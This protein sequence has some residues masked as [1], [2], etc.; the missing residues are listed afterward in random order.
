MNWNETDRDREREMFHVPSEGGEKERS[1]VF[2]KKEREKD[3]FV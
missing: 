3:I 2:W 1:S